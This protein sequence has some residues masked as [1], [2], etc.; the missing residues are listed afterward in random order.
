MPNDAAMLLVDGGILTKLTFKMSLRPASTGKTT[1]CLQMDWL[2]SRADGVTE[3]V[4]LLN[5]A[6]KTEV[7][8]EGPYGHA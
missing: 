5:F 6:L 4:C 7:P 1:L 2:A 8:H 3:Y